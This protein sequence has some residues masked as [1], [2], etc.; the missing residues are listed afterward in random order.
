VA[1]VPR[2]H[3]SA[4]GLS[5]NALSRLLAGCT[6]RDDDA[7]VSRRARTM[8]EH[9]DMDTSVAERGRRKRDGARETTARRPSSLEGF[10]FL[11]ER[12]KRRV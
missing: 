7:A 6:A 12:Q 3:P 10:E 4:G 1:Y 9:A 5:G 2:R 8:G 11:V